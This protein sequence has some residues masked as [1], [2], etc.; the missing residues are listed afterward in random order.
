MYLAK[1]Q[2]K[3]FRCLDEFSIEFGPGLNVIVGPNNAGKTAILEA[4]SLVLSSSRSNPSREIYV[5]AEDFWHSTD[6]TQKEEQEFR[7]ALDICDIPD[8][9]LGFYS[10]WLL[11]TAKSTARIS[12]ICRRD[13]TDLDEVYPG[14]W[15]GEKNIDRPEEESL[16]R[17][18]P[19]F[20]PPLR[21]A[22]SNLR[23]GR[24]NRLARLVQQIVDEPTASQIEKKLGDLQNDLIVQPPF[25]LAAARINSRLAKASGRFYK[26]IA[27]L[28]FLDPE[29]RRIAELLQVRLGQTGMPAYALTEN[30]LGYNNLLYIATI[31]S[32][33]SKDDKQDLRLLLIEEPE[34]HLNPQMQQV[35]VDALIEAAG[36]TQLNDEKPS[37]IIVT[38]HSPLL[39]AHVPINEIIVL[40]HHKVEPTHPA[41][42][43]GRLNKGKPL[44]RSINKFGLD[45]KTLNDLS[46]YLDST[47]S[48]LFFAEGVILVE[49]IAESLL[50][51]V[52]AKALNRPLNEYHVSIVN[53]D[54]LA[55]EP[56]LN[57]FNSLERLQIPCALV[58][59]SDPHFNLGD[60]FYSSK[61]NK[62]Q[63]EYNEDSDDEVEGDEILFPDALI[64]YGRAYK[65]ENGAKQSPSGAKVFRNLKTLEYDL[66]LSDYL[67]D[68]LDAYTV[69]DQDQ[70]KE[71]REAI[72]K[73]DDTR[74][75]A[76][77]FY[78]RFSTKQKGVFAQQLAAHLDQSILKHWDKEK[79]AKGDDRSAW[80]VYKNLPD[81]IAQAICWVTG[82]CDWDAAIGVQ[83]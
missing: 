34:A 2:T 55:F 77:R 17:L 30:G 65:L 49:G 44:A 33:L 22:E 46:R 57:L 7:I 50:F 25:S 15:V 42:Y 81:Y 72:A 37:Q 75:K 4:I 71:M 78:K 43:Q 12:L 47:K 31:L 83:K 38:S 27:H 18:L 9:A 79:N 61:K 62:P 41:N 11:P 56:F 28:K 8:T 45:A 66:A 74:K 40:N 53:V 14:W 39:A 10:K 82:D 35:L 21:D 48:N 63:V 19:V 64:Q 32:Q 5:N 59:D 36:N 58:T 76:I 70:A 60:K 23:P 1:L 73:V 26:Q 80:D 24:R 13:P 3:G 69:V 16:R 54:G 52:F 29:F 51:P 68:M 6:G 67:S 20:L